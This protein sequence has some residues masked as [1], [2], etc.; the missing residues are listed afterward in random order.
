MVEEEEVRIGERLEA[1]GASSKVNGKTYQE[2]TPGRRVATPVEG[3]RRPT[4]IKELRDAL[5]VVE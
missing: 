4:E 5:D 1:D 2:E 3:P